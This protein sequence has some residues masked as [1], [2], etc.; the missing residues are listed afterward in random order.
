MFTVHDLPS[1][2]YAILP[3]PA[4]PPATKREAVELH[5]TQYPAERIDAPVVTV[6]HDWP[7]L[8]HKIVFVPS[9]TA[10]QVLSSGEKAIPLPAVV[11]KDVPNP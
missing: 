8:D 11:K 3:V 5:A 2:E 6:A 9:P 1:L 7:S 10:T 4:A